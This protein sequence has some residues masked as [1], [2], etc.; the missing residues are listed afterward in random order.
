M[1]SIFLN[2]RLAVLFGI[3]LFSNVFGQSNFEIPRQVI[4]ED[5]EF[6]V[7][8]GDTIPDFI[9]TLANGKKVTSLDWRGK[10]VMLQF[11]ASWC[12]VCRK[13]IPFIQKDIW[14][15]YKRNSDFLLFGID[16]DEPIEKV[17]Q[18]QKEMNINYPLALDQDAEV[19]GLFADKRAGVTRN[20]IIDRTGKI[21]FM[22]RLF[23]EKEFKEMVR[24]ISLL[25]K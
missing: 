5:Y 9:L 15:K 23:K 6:T 3:L 4:P 13:E 24:I 1:R 12:G 18:Y 19:F 22:T 8:I 10:V 17:K 2:P 14:A 21:V 25:L 11:T 7:K 20:V 16:R